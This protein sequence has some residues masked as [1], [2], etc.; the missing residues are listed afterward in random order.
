MRRRCMTCFLMTGLFAMMLTG[1]ERVIST[2][3]DT[4][5][6][7]I[8]VV[9]AHDTA[10]ETETAPGMVL[11]SVDAN[12]VTEEVPDLRVTY[13]SSFGY[14]MKYDKAV[15]EYNQHGGYDE[16]V[17]KTKAFSSDPLVFFAAMRIEEPDIET[18]R[19]EVFGDKPVE[20]T[21]GTGGYP[22]LCMRS[23]ETEGKYVQYHETS[24]VMLESGDALLFEI[25]WFV[26]EKNEDT[27][28]EQLASMLA[29]L[30][31]DHAA[32]EIPAAGEN[33]KNTVNETEEE[34]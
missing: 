20:G 25:Q 22:A 28:G 21:I 8:V 15:F 12:Q 9:E 31:I 34:K 27:A 10:A 6:S 33:R 24:M 1:C 19:N 7:A 2:V 14:R 4:E 26:P 29:S 3:P 23:E 13:E 17:M 5:T 11:E 30:E 32:A 16:F 18:I